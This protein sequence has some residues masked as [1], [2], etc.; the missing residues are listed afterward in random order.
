MRSAAWKNTMATDHTAGAPP[1]LG[2]INLVNIGWIANT[3]RAD[4]NSVAA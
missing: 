4:T 2:R 3:S 1:T